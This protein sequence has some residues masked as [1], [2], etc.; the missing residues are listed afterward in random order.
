[1]PRYE[2]HA[3][4]TRV[5]A[6]AMLSTGVLHSSRTL[7]QFNTQGRNIQEGGVSCDGNNLSCNKPAA[8]PKAP[9]P[10]AQ[11]PQ[12]QLQQ[13]QSAGD[14]YNSGVQCTGSAND[15]PPPAAV[16]EPPPAQRRPFA[17]AG[18]PPAVEASQGQRQVCTGNASCSR[19][20]G[21]G[22]TLVQTS[23]GRPGAAWSSADPPR[24]AAMAPSPEQALAMPVASA[25]MP[26]TTQKCVDR[27]ACVT[28][29]PGEVVAQNNGRR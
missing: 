28:T 25:P 12:Q 20:T 10:A 27:A 13:A 16:V 19:S 5:A 9:G 4:T 18:P 14:T 3:L 26:A 6:Q 2:S 23:N 21:T 7:A 24:P 17:G 22:N 1:M 11:L 8:V 15:C 29:A